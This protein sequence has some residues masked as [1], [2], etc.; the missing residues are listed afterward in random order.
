MNFLNFR[1]VLFPWTVGTRDLIQK[2]QLAE[3]FKWKY[4]Y[5]YLFDAFS[6]ANMES[7]WCFIALSSSLF[8]EVISYHF[9]PFFGGVY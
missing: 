3:I 7:V 1:L 8:V 4:K 6:Y 9:L 2:R 5:V